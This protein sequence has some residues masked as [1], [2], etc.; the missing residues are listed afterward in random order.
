MRFQKAPRPAPAPPGRRRL[1][2]AAAA[3]VGALVLAAPPGASAGGPPAAIE[4]LDVSH[5]SGAVDWQRVRDAGVEFAYVKATEGVDSPDPAFADHWRRLGELGIARGAYHF[6]V[7]EDDPEAQA[8]FFLATVAH[9]PGDLPPAVD[10][11]LIGH[12]TE[13]GLA[14]RLRTFLEI[15]GREIGV[16][17]LVYT[18]PKFWNAHLTAAFGDHLLWIAEYGVAEPQIP[19]GWERWTLWQWQDS[20]SVPGV[21]KD[22]DRS[23]L[24]PELTLDDLRVPV[25]SPPSPSTPLPPAQGGEGRPHPSSASG[26]L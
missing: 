18:S 13:P 26:R 19:E 16:R 23:R 1:P 24:H 15:V 3:L 17:P 10:I 14:G 11:E 7:T 12:G 5:Y 20:G 8:R 22:A 2:L 4:G 6:Y 21:E 25:R 9:R